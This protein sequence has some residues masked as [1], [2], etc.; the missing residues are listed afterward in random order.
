MP[1]PQKSPQSWIGA[2]WDPRGKG[3][4]VDG[5]HAPCVPQRGQYEV[6]RMVQIT[7]P[8]QP[9]DWDRQAGRGAR[10]WRATAGAFDRYIAEAEVGWPR[11][12]VCADVP[13]LKSV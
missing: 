11:E 5:H 6:R 9:L 12:R 4:I 8:R 3:Q 7:V 1:A 10:R 2:F 13:A